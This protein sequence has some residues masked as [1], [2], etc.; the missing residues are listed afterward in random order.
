[1]HPHEQE[2]DADHH[3]GSKVGGRKVKECYHFISPGR[4][5]LTKSSVGVPMPDC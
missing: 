3:T 4:M 5:V 2:E 1:M